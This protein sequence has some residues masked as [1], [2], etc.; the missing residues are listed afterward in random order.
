MRKRV[1]I[2]IVMAVLMLQG[3]L[4]AADLLTPAQEDGI[5]LMRE[6]E[7]LARD[8][9]LELYDTWGIETFNNIASSEQQ[10]MS[11]V[12]RIID[13]YGIKDPITANEIGLFTDPHL[14]ELYEDLIEKGSL[15]AL[16]ALEVGI[17]IEELDI[18]DLQNLMVDDLPDD[19]MRTYSNL[20]RGSER[21]L[22]SFESQ[23]ERSSFI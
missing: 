2:T 13:R 20:L 3:I 23:I 16:D 18:S 7:K 15:S 1:I 4:F 21:H 17:M 19:I 14:A 6:E 22:D 8:V 9:Y 5:I 12:G 11:S 10:H